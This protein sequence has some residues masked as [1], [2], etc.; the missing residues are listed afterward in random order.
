MNRVQTMTHKHHRVENQVK[1]PS[2]VREHPVS[3]AGT[4]RCAL[5]RPGARMGAVSWPGPR[6]CRGK[7]P[8]V[9]QA[10]VVVS[11]R[12]CR[13]PRVLPPVP[14]LPTPAPAHLARLLRAQ[15]R[16]VGAVPQAWPYRG[17]VCAQAWPYR[18]LPR[19]TVPNRL[20]TLVTI[21]YL[22]LRYNFLPSQTYNTV[23]I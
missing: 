8:V 11:Q 9:S 17:R 1:K 21:H 7:G 6:P 14:Q 10:L 18:G 5:A 13:T 15:R 19:D 22:V 16:V 12:L 4:P 2:R 23:T 20:A 3:P